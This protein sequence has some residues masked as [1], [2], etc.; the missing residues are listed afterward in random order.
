M[1]S[2]KSLLADEFDVHMSRYG[3]ADLDTEG[4]VGGSTD[5]VR[6]TCNDISTIRLIMP[7]RAMSLMV[8]GNIN[9]LSNLLIFIVQN[10]PPCTPPS[11][12]TEISHS[13]S[14]DCIP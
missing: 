14:S 3:Y 4:A 8:G 11:V 6:S 5:F 12:C 7:D 2:F 9:L 13:C 10:C 1:I